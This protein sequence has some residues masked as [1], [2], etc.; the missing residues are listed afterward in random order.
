M[1]SM[2]RILCKFVRWL[3]PL[4]GMFAGCGARMPREGRVLN[5][6]RPPPA[7]A[8]AVVHQPGNGQAQQQ[9][10]GWRRPQQERAVQRERPDPGPAAL[11]SGPVDHGQP[12]GREARAEHTAILPPG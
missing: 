5:H 7:Q 9:Q 3:G 12:L 2:L 4:Q 10:A 1:T 8:N 6:I 11:V